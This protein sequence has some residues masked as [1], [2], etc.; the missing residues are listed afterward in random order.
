MNPVRGRVLPVLFAATLLVGGANLAAYAA[1]GHP[2]L[3]GHS[4]SESKTATV[5]KSGSGPAL[6]LKTGANSP[7]L[8]VTSKKLVKNLN[9]DKVD[10]LNGQSLQN[11]TRSFVVPGSTAIPF[12]LALQGVPAGKY[13]ASFDIGAS[14]ATSTPMVCLI[15]DTT[16]ADQVIAYGASNGTYAVASATGPLT[17]HAGQAPV[18]Q[19]NSATAVVAAGQVVSTVTLTKVDHVTNGSTGPATRTGGSSLLTR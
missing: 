16:T 12:G 8:A 1:N 18:L 17:V 15:G 13:T 6:K 2:L 19:C 11:N 14:T 9:A 7:P 10:G 4:N 5:T 3:L